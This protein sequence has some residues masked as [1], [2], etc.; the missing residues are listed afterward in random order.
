M[1]E[2]FPRALT[3]LGVIT[4]NPFAWMWSARSRTNLP[5]GTPRRLRDN[6]APAAAG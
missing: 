2:I 4:A 3:R 5:L 6:K 1:L